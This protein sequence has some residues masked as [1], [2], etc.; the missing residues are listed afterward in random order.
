MNILNQAQAWLDARY[1]AGATT[2]GV[3]CN[4]LQRK[5]YLSADGETLVLDCRSRQ[6]TAWIKDILHDHIGQLP[7]RAGK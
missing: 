4:P 2:L 7:A 1:R 6:E 3:S 5:L